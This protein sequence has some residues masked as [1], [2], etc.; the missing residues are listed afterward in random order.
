MFGRATWLGRLRTAAQAVLVIWSLGA[1]HAGA[2]G[3]DDWPRVPTPSLPA[4]PIELRVGHVVN[5][6]F[7]RFTDSQIALMLAETTRI[8]RAHFGIELV[9][10]PVA[11]V[12]IDT[13][14]ERFDPALS[15]Y[16]DGMHY[17]VKRQT[18]N[19]QALIES[20]AGEI[21]YAAKGTGFEG[22]YDFALPHLVAPPV[23]RDTQGLAVAAVDTML[24]R[25]AALRDAD[26]RDGRPMLDEHAFNEWAYWDSIGYALL[27][28]D[29]VIT[30]QPIASAEYFG[31]GIHIALRGGITVGSTNYSRDGRYRSVSWI[32]TFPFTSAL[33]A[34]VSL[35]DGESYDAATAARLAGAYHVHELGH[36]LFGFA[37]P[38]GNDACVMTPAQLL[39][40]RRWFDG[41]D[42][43][44]CA[45]GSSPAMTVGAIRL[46]VD[47]QRQPTAR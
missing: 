45:I 8:A 13:L 28:W 26:A 35:R 7:P 23:T 4:G 27:P 11:T 34:L 18:G 46:W 5:P 15:R 6:R 40:F 12:D 24:A 19:R 37:H 31:L 1:A 44:R 39:R 29:F 14:F 20:V 22:L 3:I 30:N 9:F 41:L 33:P 2:A 21:A 10:T 25:L 47:P 17:D 16:L 42:P 43:A 32:S 38:F 36:Q